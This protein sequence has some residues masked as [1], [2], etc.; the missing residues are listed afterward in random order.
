MCDGIDNHCVY[1]LGS[2]NQF[3]GKSDNNKK[4]A[5]HQQ[6]SIPY[7]T[8]DNLSGDVSKDINLDFFISCGSG[9]FPEGH[10]TGNEVQ[11]TASY[12]Q[13]LDFDRFQGFSGLDYTA[14]VDAFT[15]NW[16]AYHILNYSLQNLRNKSCVRVCLVPRRAMIALT[17][18]NTGK[19]IRIRS[20][21]GL[22][23]IVSN[24]LSTRVPFLRFSSVTNIC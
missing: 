11:F 17:Q 20:I 19:G 13:F 24:F 7:T 3:V 10:V 8:C 22:G 6:F 12:R 23:F 16:A 21:Q 1:S 9:C 2:H 5:S 14:T 18:K 15:E 4:V